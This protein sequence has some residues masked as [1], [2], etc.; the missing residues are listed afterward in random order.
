MR[1]LRTLVA[2][3]S[4]SVLGFTSSASSTGLTTLPCTPPPADP[5]IVALARALNYDRQQIFEYVYYNI[6]YSPTYGL[7]K[8]PLATYLDGRGNNFDQNVLLVTLL[9]QSCITARYRVGLV[10]KSLAVAAEMLGVEADTDV[11]A[12]VLGDGGF[13][14]AAVLP[15]G[16]AIIPMVW[17]EIIPS[18]GPPLPI[19]YNPAFK[20][21]TV[22]NPPINI[23]AA[24]GYTRSGLLADTLN[25]SE[26]I[27]GMPPDV[28]TLKKLNRTNLTTLLNGYSE[29]L[30]NYIK[31]NFL[32]SSS[33]QLYG[34]R[35]ITSTNYTNPFLP[36]TGGTLHEELPLA[37]FGTEFIVTVSNNG[38]GSNPSLTSG[39]L[40]ASE[41]GPKRLTLTYDSSSR[42]VLALDGQVVATGSPAGANPQTVSI[43]VSHKA[44]DPPFT[45]TKLETVKVGGTY[46]VMLTAGEIGRDAATY[47]QRRLAKL[48]QAGDP[49]TSEPA[50]GEMLASMGTLYLSQASRASQLIAGIGNSVIVF[51]HHTGIAGY[52]GTSPY[53]TFPGQATSVT[54]AIVALTEAERLGQFAALG[55]YKSTLESTAVTEMQKTTAASTVLM[56]NY[57]NSDQTGFIRATAGNWSVVRPTLSGW[58]SGQ[59][60]QVGVY[61]G[62]NPNR[63]VVI[64]Q[65][66][67]RT[68]GTWTG[69]G[70][71]TIELTTVT[72]GNFGYWISSGSK[73]ADGTGWDL[74]GSLAFVWGVGAVP[75][76]LGPFGVN[77][78]GTFFDP[79]DGGT[80]RITNGQLF[81]EAF[82]GGYSWMSPTT[83]FAYPAPSS[84][85]PINLLTGAYTY[86]NEDISVGSAAFPFGLSFKRSYVSSRLTEQTAL[87][88]GWRHNFMTTAAVSS[89]SDE[90]FGDRNPLTSVALVVAAYVISDLMSDHTSAAPFPPLA[91]TLAG[92]LTASWLM[93]QLRDNAVTVTTVAGTKR[94]IKTPT[95]N[96]VGTYVPPP[97]DASVLV[98]NGDKAITMTD[99]S[100]TVMNFATNGTLTSWRD[101]NANT[102]TFTYSAATS[103]APPLLQSVSNG[104]GRTLTLTYNGSSQLTAVSD[105]S[106]TVTYSY[107]SAGNLSTF[108]NSAPTPATTTYVYDQPGRL[109]QMFFPS[110]PSTAF[111]TNVYDQF[112]RV[113]TQ[114]DA[115][116]NVWFYLFANGKRS[117]EIDPEGGSHTL[118]F[119]R[120]GNQTVDVDATNNRRTTAYDG[121]GR[122]TLITSPNGDT[123]QLT[124][125]AKHNVL[126][127]IQTPA[128]NQTDL[129]IAVI[130]DNTDIVTGLPPVPITQSW[131]YHPIF[132]KVVTATDGRGNTTTNT[133]DANGNVLTVTQ[134]AVTKPAVPGMAN[135]VSTFSYAARGLPATTTDAEGRVTAF[136]YDPATFDLLSV[137]QDDVNLK[138]KT[139]YTYD[140]VGNRITV[141]DPKGNTTT[142]A[143]DGMRRATQ[144]TAPL[145]AMTT[146]GYDP[147]GRVTAESRATGIP[148]A[149]WQTTITTY[150][151]AGKALKVTLA[152]GTSTTN[153]YDVV[154]RLSTK[155]S[156]GGRQ[157][158]YNYDLASRPTKITDQGDP[159]TTSN[160]SPVIREQRAYGL[161]GLLKALADGKGNALCFYYDGFKRLKEIVYP[162][163][164]ACQTPTDHELYGYDANG[165]SLKF[166]TRSGAEINSTFDA[167]NRRLTK[168]PAGQPSIGYGYDYTG[169][170]LRAF[171]PGDLYRFI[172]DTAGRLTREVTPAGEHIFVTLDAN[173]NPIRL[174][175]PASAGGLITTQIYDELNRLTRVNEGFGGNAVRISQYGYN[176]LSQRTSVSYGPI[177]GAV[178]SSVLTY[179][180]A[181]QVEALR[182]NFNGPDLILSYAYNQDQQQKGVSSTDATFLPPPSTPAATA[183][184]SNALNQYSSVAGTPF[185]YD[186]RGNLTGDG[187]WT[188]GY[189]TENRLISATSSSTAATYAYD[190]LGRR[191]SKTVNG[192]TT[193]WMSF[194]HQEIAEFQGPSGGALGLTKQ[195]V[196]GPKLDEPAVS[197]DAS[198]T[199]IYHFR[200][201]LGSIIA[202][203]NS[204]GQLT[205]KYAYTAYGSA[206]VTGAGTAPY[207]FTGRRFDAE[208]GLYH[209]RARAYSSTL[210]RFLQVDPIGTE[211]GINLYAYVGNDP[212]NGL[213]PFGL[214]T[215]QTGTSLG[216]GLL[217][218][219]VSA[220]PGSHYASLAQQ[221]VAQGNYGSAAVYGVVS[222]LDAAIG[223]A[224]FGLSTRVGAAAR[225]VTQYEVGTFNA[226]RARSAVGDQLDIHHAVQSHPAGQVISNYGWANSPAIALPQA[227][228]QLLPTFS[229]SFGGTARSLLANDIRN[230]RNYTNAPNNSLQKLIELNKLMYPEVFA[231]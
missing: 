60:D 162:P 74:I 48:T 115:H 191:S 201:A 197:F 203:A 63:Q 8:S 186:A 40:Y 99:K 90:A 102:V 206:V 207:R 86:D 225:A 140:T 151:A 113:E 144:I 80:Y 211:G 69:S 122:A 198:N 11:V 75:A 78:I 21:Y 189:D 230:L 205:E 170:L 142:T 168:A 9:R 65:I 104:M 190:A 149:P 92:S 67:N 100:Q 23:G 1:K 47:H 183:Y 109:T 84:S 39:S 123:Q 139:S 2:A 194:G 34:G 172:Y 176:P 117:Q 213:D 64:P 146:Y 106:R 26:P 178:A 4:M 107:D 53:V 97:G 19:L 31:T 231:K 55:M 37:T 46:A 175:R 43:K 30:S 136:A 130:R 219:T 164:S 17:T 76:T 124:Y 141:V 28:E 220:V 57:A 185:T 132:N 217:Q 98:V 120:G 85:E 41:I 119:D 202:L 6:E 94:F 61:L 116:G 200:D 195:F 103:S 12:G 52:D 5:E 138:L 15:G 32:A 167:I 22:K 214:A 157:A 81:C 182:H 51:H 208:T 16:P 169:R 110:F 199:R 118:H 44:Y 95:A 216:Q 212:V 155:T 93:D 161:G 58:Q 204:G 121:Q 25:G 125:D 36:G 112:G 131:T 150:D 192:T 82:C 73:G 128:P 159:S 62:T 154:G 184:V 166:V 158:V 91:N 229:G 210:G 66:G 38:D 188:Y 50:M 187:T 56:F 89:D 88:Y 193:A 215:A 49:P 108:T 148:A 129:A 223:I 180:P 68:V 156:S 42:P 181:G 134:P 14:D 196:Y 35:E 111:M 105:G 145:G 70:Y 20:S 10:T 96:G 147:D 18:V 152:D 137:T 133:Y 101:P 24:T 54:R 218:S 165:N 177:G 171:G 59:L 127:S 226:L 13:K 227:E 87:G 3:L 228:H 29:N 209:Y 79:A 135:P 72:A 160:P 83:Q 126:S 153:A 114:A 221:Q 174:T 224:S 163:Y 7:K 77:S 45:S 33:R 143:Y 173:G 222:V 71:Y 179:T 27:S